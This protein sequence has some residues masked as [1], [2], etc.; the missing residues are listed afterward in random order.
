MDAEYHRQKGKEHY[1]KYKEKYAA[2][3]KD[4]RARN[5]AI[6]NE[7][8]K[9]GCTRCD[10]KDPACLDFHHLGG[11]DAKVSSLVNCSEQRL[12][13]EIE[14]CIV[15]CANCHRKEHRSTE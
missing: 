3:S 9:D 7:Y 4:V 15:L 12:R 6:M 8:R 1:Q 11:K 13:A 10:E 2:R 14:K 5:Y